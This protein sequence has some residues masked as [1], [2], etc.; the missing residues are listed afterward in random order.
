[1]ESIQQTS[2]SVEQDAGERLTFDQYLQQL[3]AP[4]QTF[5]RVIVWFFAAAFLITLGV[6]IY[7][8]Y[9][10]F[11]AQSLGGSH[12]VVAWMSFFLAGAV[13]AFLYGLDTL[14]LGATIPMPSEGSKYSYETGPKAVREGWMLIGYGV[15]VIILYI[16]GVAAVQAGRFV[17]ED[18]VTLV[19]GFFVILGLGSAALAVLR[20]ILRPSSL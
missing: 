10:S 20:R 8:I 7:A 11:M 16:V 1:M 15:V 2:T 14:V 13:A 17:V 18:F 19:V 5:H 3:P 9:A 6:F 4:K 12:V